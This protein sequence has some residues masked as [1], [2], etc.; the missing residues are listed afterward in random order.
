MN[1]H[2]L[3]GE[4]RKTFTNQSGFIGNRNPLG[5]NTLFPVLEETVD[6]VATVTRI[7]VWVVIH[8]CIPLFAIVITG[9]DVHMF[10]Q[11]N[12]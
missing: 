10:F 7:N 8:E 3:S 2:K 11:R 6:D 5:K 9:D 12:L 4:N 1:L